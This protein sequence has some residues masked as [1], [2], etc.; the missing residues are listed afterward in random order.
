[1]H[2]NKTRTNSAYSA[3]HLCFAKLIPAFWFC[4]FY[5][6]LCAQTNTAFHYTGKK[7]VVCNHGAVVSAHPLASMA[8]LSVMKQGGNAVDAAIATQFALAVVFPGAGNLG[9]GGFMVIRLAGNKNITVDF[10]EK[11][12]GAATRDMYLD[13]QGNP[14][15][16]KSI[17]GHLASGVPGSVA[18]IFDALQYARLPIKKIIQ[19][20]I[21]LAEKGFAITEAEARSL[22]AA[23]ESFK[24]YNTVLPVFVKPSGWKAGDTLIQK[25]LAKTLRL[26]RDQGAKGFYAGT[27]ARLIVEEMQ[28]GKGLISYQDLTNYRAKERDPM[29]FT[30]KKN[31]TIITM[32][33][34]SSGGILLPQMMRMVE[35]RNLGA[36]GFH[37][38][39][40]IHLMAEV[41]RLAYADRAKFLGDPDFYKV[42]VKTLI[43]YPYLRER[44]TGF[45]P[46]SAGKSEKVQAGIIGESDETTHLDTY[47]KDGNAV[48][49]TTTLN[50]WYG[51]KV[52]VGHAGFFLNN[53]MDDFSMKPG[54]PNMFGAIG[55]EANAIRPGKRMLSSMT[56]TIVLKNGQ[57]FLVAGTPGGTTIITS[58]FQ[59]LVNIIDFNLS[60][61]DAVNMP[62]F[63]HQWLPD[64]LFVERG[65]PDSTLS[66]LHNMGYKTAER[67]SIGRT[68]VIRISPSGIEAVAD[69]R[70][71]D[72]AEGF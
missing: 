6:P 20:A 9:G 14:V 18:G 71:D 53:E 34:P 49:L 22:N 39:K 12:P 29:V 16:G 13:A 57:P 30:Y 50:G 69:G 52:V 5:L 58:V 1:M 63:H 26:I 15:K 37:S 45:N 7:K 59:T 31:Y 36:D 70:G 46:D 43:S 67:G 8:G 27:T 65:F 55:G 10:R 41:E 66:G 17:N 40:S 19:P 44:M 38:L 28:R 61:E 47:D 64:T 25:D 32:P 2:L 72:G 24:K 68:E 60:T 4:L 42:P 3:F 51:C 62:K 23:Q 54:V 33:L 48:S 11:A 56:P 21:D 35:D